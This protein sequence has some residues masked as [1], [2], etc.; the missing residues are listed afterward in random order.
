MTMMGACRLGVE[1]FLCGPKMAN[2]KSDGPK[3]MKWLARYRCCFTPLVST[4]GC[5]WVNRFVCI[6]M[7][8]RIFWMLKLGR[9]YYTSRGFDLFASLKKIVAYNLLGTKLWN[10]LHFSSCP[11]LHLCKNLHKPSE[12][13]HFHRFLHICLTLK[14]GN[15]ALSL[16]NSLKIIFLLRHCLWCSMP[17]TLFAKGLN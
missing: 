15:V 14:K 5:H 6:R 16:K 17:R 7:Q 9:L 1:W 3:R 12:L 8:S 2:W 4:L 10:Y 11:L 13:A